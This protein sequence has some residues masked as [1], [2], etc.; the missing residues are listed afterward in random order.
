MSSQ[1]KLLPLVLL[2]LLGSTVAAQTHRA[3]IRGTVTDPNGAVIPGAQVHL[4]NIATGDSRVAVSGA[5]GQYAIS[6]LQPGVY[7]LEV[8]VQSFRKHTQRIEVLVNQEQ[9]LDVR[10]TSRGPMRGK[11]IQSTSPWSR[12]TRRRSAP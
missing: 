4:T 7:Q 6:S 2:L 3:S 8:E 9:R 10:W 12:R 11:L 1:R 5:E